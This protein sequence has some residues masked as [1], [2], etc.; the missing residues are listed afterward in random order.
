VTLRLRL[1]F[2]Y[3]TV[4]ALIISLFGAAVYGILAASLT[5]QI[6]LGLAAAAD[7][8]IRTSR[9]SPELQTVHIPPNLD[10]FGGPN[11]YVQVWR[12]D[13]TLFDQSASLGSYTDPLDSRGLAEGRQ[14]LRDVRIGRIHLRVLT[15][16][17]QTAIDNQVVGY[18]QTAANLGVLD[19]AKSQ[20]LLILIGGGVAAVL[21]AAL[22]GGM[23]VRQALQPLEAIT[24]TALKITRADDLSRR[25]PMDGAPQDEV[26]RLGMAFNESLERLERLFN[27]Q[28]RFLADV[29]HELRTPLTA[30]RGNVD[31]L[32]RM[33]G[34]DPTSLDAI[35]SEAERMS[36]LVGD[37]LLLAQ[38]DS[39]NLPLARDRVELDTLLLEVFREAQMLA[40]GVHVSIGEID[41]AVVIGDRDRLKQLLLNLVSNAVTYTPEGGRVTLGLA[42]VNEFAR[43]A[44]SDTGVGIP[45][46][47]LP[48]IFDRFYRVD[49]ARS[50]LMGGAGL[51]LSIAQ[52]I[53]HLHGGRLEAM[54]EG[55][56]KGTTF[57]VWLPLARRPTQATLAA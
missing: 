40:A 39:G 25:I 26:G 35:Q 54:S 17:M 15:E 4:L 5:R 7:E 43:I 3:S 27:A 22:V 6:D 33:G 16:P 47:E 24:Q 56:G 36:R 42:R 48:H 34:A 29:S 23:T 44:V 53:A 30:I 38:A 28:R 13:N 9:F 2:W 52:R 12:T 57:C 50:R 46:D 45:P 51:G 14:S 32:R 49:K 19:D 20:L 55:E 11:I 10:Q 1:T 18:V 8:I 31:L 21:L 37:L 41:Q